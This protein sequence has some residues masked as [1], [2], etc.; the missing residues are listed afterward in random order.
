MTSR[1]E[2]EELLEQNRE[3]YKTH[4]YRFVADRNRI[5][6]LL[7]RIQQQDGT[8]SISDSDY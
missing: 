2:T 5:T 7:E 4:F 8:D 3:F 6:E 1:K